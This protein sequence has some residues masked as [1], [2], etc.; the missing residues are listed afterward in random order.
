[1]FTGIVTDVGR[2]RQIRRDGDVRFAIET[3]YDTAT[4]EIGASIGGDI[5]H[6][7]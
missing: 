5:I 7:M 2:V 6:L 3:A 1:M 4:I